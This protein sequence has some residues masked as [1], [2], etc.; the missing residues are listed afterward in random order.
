MHIGKLIATFCFVDDYEIAV[1]AQ[2]YSKS[3]ANVLREA[4]KIMGLC[5]NPSTRS[6]NTDDG[7][8]V[9]LAVETTFVTNIS[10][11]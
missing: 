10:S 1:S 3:I 2:D 5:Y 4:I 8:A 9:C 6:V 7:G 11:V